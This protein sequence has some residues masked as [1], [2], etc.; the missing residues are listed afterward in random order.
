MDDIL[1]AK[2]DN[3]DYN[4]SGHRGIC[5]ISP[6]LSH[7][8]SVLL[9]YIKELA[10][11]LYELNLMG[12]N[13]EKIKNDFIESF[14]AFIT[15]F[16]YTQETFDQV[17]TT[18][19]VSLYQSK[20]FYKALCQKN[21]IS[22]K[23][24]KSKLRITQ[25][26]TVSEA[27]RQ[28]KKFFAKASGSLS[29]EI[30]QRFDLLIVVLKSIYIYMIELQ[31][32]NQNIDDCYKV[33]LEALWPSDI[34][35]LKIKDVDDMIEKYSK[36]DH[37]LMKK[38]YHLR[39]DLFG[40][41][42]ETEVCYSTRESKAI[43]VAGANINELES[44]LKATQGKAIDVYTHGQMIA[45]HIFE[46]IKSYPH[47]AGHYGKGLDYTLY[48]FAYFPGPIF[49]TKLSQYKIENLCRGNIFTSD[50]IA[51]EGII[52]IKDNDFSSL[53]NAAINEEGF[54][55]SL[56]A[57]CLRFG[58]KEEKFFPQVEILA[59]RIEKGEIKNLFTIGVSNKAIS[60]S[61]YFHEF[62]SLLKEDDFVISFSYTNYSQ[63][64]LN[65]NIDYAFPI[66][67]Q[68]LEI[69]NKKKS[70]KELNPK[71]LI[72][73]CEVHTIPNLFYLKQMG[74]ETMYLWG[75]S[76]NLLNPA[77]VVFAQNA[78][79]VKKFTTPHQDMQDMRG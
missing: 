21:G 62:L 30:R 54:T 46:K 17:I 48:D 32:L 37:E 5:S 73:R 11:Y 59:D 50:T 16:E 27:I 42:I 74:V 9:V 14:T 68:A 44:I 41:F 67:Y 76:P 7:V 75:C 36:F 24:T 8:Q 23:Y 18:L 1:S 79:N 52:K 72:T 12:Y 35:T 13:N 20:E 28:A 26:F 19:Y 22:P 6:F 78:L 15:N 51:S 53:I 58:F 34:K 47:F 25:K 69:I 10:F 38:V 2:N 63:N 40:D 57:E 55:K 64:I 61:Q 29:E 65:I 45:G 31:Q 49:L 3:A 39:K 33:L 43:L 56:E 4:E 60:Q 70:L 71:I 77:L 66:L